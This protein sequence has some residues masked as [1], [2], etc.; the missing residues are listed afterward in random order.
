M[1]RLFM[2]KF[3]IPEIEGMTDLVKDVRDRYK[4]RVFMLNGLFDRQI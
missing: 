1:T 2:I 3:N 4:K